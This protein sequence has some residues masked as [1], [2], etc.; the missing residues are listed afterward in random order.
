VEAIRIVYASALGVLGV[1]APDRMDLP[2]G[3]ETDAV[4]GEGV[5]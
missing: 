5:A 1:S 2:A 3:A 4:E